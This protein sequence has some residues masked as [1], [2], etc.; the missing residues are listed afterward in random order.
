MAMTQGAD[1]KRKW[2]VPGIAII[3]VVIL[4]TIALVRDPVALD[5]TTP[6]GTVQTYLQA[7]SEEDYEKAH[8]Q[9]S[10]EL[11]KKCSVEDLATN[12]YYDSFS[13]TLGE[14]DELGDAVL[15]EVSIRQGSDPG[16][17]DP[18]YSFSPDPFRL[19]RE[20]ARWVISGDPWPIYSYGC[21]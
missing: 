7:I 4:T 8:S 1:R 6:E 10:A 9:M 18:G 13:A 20:D 3:A 12:N 2:L 15:V 11:Q 17:I 21:N 5:P 14:V 16:F 19:V